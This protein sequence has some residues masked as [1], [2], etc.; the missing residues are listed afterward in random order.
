MKD[1]SLTNVA[2]LRPATTH[3]ARSLEGRARVIGAP[4]SPADFASWGI[5]DDLSLD[6]KG[7]CEQVDGKNE[8]LPGRNRPAALVT[9]PRRVTANASTIVWGT[10]ASVA[11]PRGVGRSEV[12]GSGPAGRAFIVLAGWRTGAP[13]RFAPRAERPPGDYPFRQAA[14]ESDLVDIPCEVRLETGDCAV[15]DSN[16]GG[17]ADTPGNGAGCSRTPVEFATDIN[18]DALYLWPCGVIPWEMEPG[19]LRGFTGAQA[20]GFLKQFQIATGMW[21]SA[22]EGWVVFRPRHAGDP[23]WLRVHVNQPGGSNGSDVGWGDDTVAGHPEYQLVNLSVN[24]GA[25]G[26]AHELGHAIG[27]GHLQVRRDRDEWMRIQ[28]PAEL[29]AANGCEVRV[30][31]VVDG[32]NR[33]HDQSDSVPLLDCFDYGG[34]SLNAVYAPP[35]GVTRQPTV[36]ADGDK[37]TDNLVPIWDLNGTGPVNPTKPGFQ[38]IGTGGGISSGD[39][40]RIHQYYSVE[41]HRKWGYFENLGWR[42]AVRAGCAPYPPKPWLGAMP[43]GAFL[44]PFAVGTPAVGFCA[45]QLAI[46]VRGSDG[47]L[48]FNSLVH[49]AVWTPAPPIVGRILSDPALAVGPDGTV[50]IAYVDAVGRLSQISRDR[51]GWSGPVAISG[52][53]PP[54]GMA[55]GSGGFCA[56][57]MTASDGR[58]VFTVGADQR[59]Y[60]SRFSLGWGQWT[61]IDLRGAAPSTAFCVAHGADGYVIGSYRPNTL[62]IYKGASLATVKPVASHIGAIVPG[63]RP[64]IVSRA[65]EPGGYRIFGVRV[66]DPSKLRFPMLWMMSPASGWEP[67]GGIP[68]A[69]TSP[70]AAACPDFRCGAF[71]SLTL[72]MVERPALDSQ[73]NVIQPGSLWRRSID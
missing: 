23:H 55:V 42:E 71:G 34:I 41:R 57:M 43:A 18:G 70:A 2:D 56:P 39:I 62:S 51:R 14:T 12:T 1:R 29:I 38:P 15:D 44:P 8:G 53:A 11:G 13:S 30:Q 9:V 68:T 28:T 3:V 46:A 47:A 54:T 22:L 40:S 63:T 6:P 31:L 65:S 48:Y 66:T 61:P 72:I 59:L 52:G 32:G 24:N 37:I 10:L 50:H 27:V 69:E 64:A 4:I 7:D 49:G 5:A 60:Y 73:G 67:I 45:G 35:D 20:L 58:V 21:N 25:F 19:G 17:V 26:I 33:R 36:D 16:T